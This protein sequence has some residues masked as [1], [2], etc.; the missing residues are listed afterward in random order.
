MKTAGV[1]HAAR[2]RGGGVAAC[3]ARAAGGH[4]GDRVPQ[5]WGARR[6]T[7]ELTGRIPPGPKRRRLCRGP[8]V[9][10]EYRWAENQYDRLPD[11]G[12]RS[13]S[14]PGERSSPRQ[15]ARLRRS[16]PRR[17]LRRF[18]SSFSVGTDP[19]KAGL[20]AS[21]NRPGGNVTGMTTL[22][23]V[24]VVKRLE[25]LH[26][27]APNAV[28]A[29]LLNPKLEARCLRVGGR[30]KWRLVLSGCQSMSFMRART[31]TSIRSLHP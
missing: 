1:H 15:A 18:Q 8:N 16:R 3:G 28:M 20:V 12:G 29:V 22:S 6:R 24:L 19:V 11:A 4:A 26:E 31:P 21:L 14:P 17:R 23:A 10:I 13:G 25:L 27:L 5:C 9:A 7:A 30:R 2:R